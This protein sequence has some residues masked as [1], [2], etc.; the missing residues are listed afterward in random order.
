MPEDTGSPQKEKVCPVM[1]DGNNTHNYQHCVGSAC[2]WWY[3]PEYVGR[4]CCAIL[5]IARGAAWL[6]QSEEA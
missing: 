1:S 2:A 6:A 3:E 4:S 5:R